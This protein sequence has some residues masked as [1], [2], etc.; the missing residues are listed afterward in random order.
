MKEKESL[1]QYQDKVR[2][3]IAQADEKFKEAQ[4]KFH[5]CF[6]GLFRSMAQGVARNNNRRLSGFWPMLFY[7]GEANHTAAQ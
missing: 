3:K 6:A 7:G 2:M 1:L 5:P 4:S